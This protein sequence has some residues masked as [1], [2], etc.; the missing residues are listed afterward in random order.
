MCV[1]S[2]FLKKIGDKKRH[3]KKLKG[4]PCK[5]CWP[6]TELLSLLELKNIDDNDSTEDIIRK[7]RGKERRQKSK[8]K[9][10]KKKKRP[11]WSSQRNK[12]I[13]RVISYPFCLLGGTLL[14][15]SDGYR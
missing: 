9:G 5:W 1:F 8:K 10:G 12:V 2:N 3:N 7:W 4:F 14:I 13:L 6:C 15:S 11:P